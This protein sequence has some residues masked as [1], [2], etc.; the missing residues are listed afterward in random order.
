MLQQRPYFLPYMV[1]RDFGVRLDSLGNLLAIL[2]GVA[3]DAQADR[4]FDYITAAGVDQPWPVRANWPV[5][6]PGERD[7]RDYYLLRNLNQ[8]DQ[9]HNGG[10]WPYLGGFYVAALVKAGR[11]ARAEQVLARLAEMN[12]QSRSGDAAWEFN[13]WLHG[14]SGRPMGFAGQSWSAAMF[15]WAHESVHIGRCPVFNHDN[16]W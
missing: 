13:E 1:F 10:C 9:Y 7:W 6:R 15:V 16:G 5:I 3:D 11:L 2:F 14:V 4:I 12:A 8:P